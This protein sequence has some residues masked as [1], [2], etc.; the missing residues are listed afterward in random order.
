[1]P[2]KP[3]RKHSAARAVP[4]AMQAPNRVPKERYYDR[5]FFELEKEKLWNK[6]WQMACR[7]Q[8]IPRPNDFVE[9]EIC[10]QSILVVRQADRSVRAFFNVCPHRATQIAKGAGTLPG[11]QL[12]CPFHGWRW[13][14]DG[15]SSFVYGQHG[16]APEC[17][18]REE[19]NLR[20]CKV[21]LWGDAVWI[22]LDPQ[23]APLAESLQ[24]AAR[25][26]EDISI[27]NLRVKWW[28]ETI[29]DANWKMAQ[30]AFMEGWHVMRTHPQLTLGAGEAT[31]PDT[32]RYGTYP[33]GHCSFESLALERGFHDFDTM[34]ASSQLLVDG[35]DAMALQRDTNILESVRH[36]LNAGDSI[37]EAVARAMRAAN[38]GAGVPMPEGIERR[39]L[40]WS[41]M[42]F[43]FPNI[44]YLPM[45]GNALAYRIRPYYNDPERCRFEVW[46]LTTWPAS[47]PE[48]RATLKGRFDKGDKQNWPLIPIQDFSNIER[49]Q[50]GLHVL[51]YQ[52][53][54]LAT[55]WEAGI[56]NMH[57]E[58]DRR[59]AL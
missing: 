12:T 32:L 13:N 35:L 43:L 50:K 36:T 10:D 29:L 34:L 31:P 23:S 26:L 46:S 14:S 33:N 2:D 7:Q 48:T 1:M 44:F 19:I 20:E 27:Q 51:G 22:N 57:R 28:Q 24:P 8:E 54:R 4:F 37:L 15:S 39:P 40:W 56:A 11:G 5:G 55:E 21:E 49:Q 58:L 30:E 18:T 42:V 9:Y 6:V 17:V 47:Y 3:S 45:Y 16:F 41:G 59:L 38:E 52:G 53:H 25:M